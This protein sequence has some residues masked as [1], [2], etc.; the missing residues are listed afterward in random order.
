[1]KVMTK[2]HR[3]GKDPHTE[4]AGLGFLLVFMF[5]MALPIWERY[6]GA[7]PAEELDQLD[8]D[9]DWPSGTAAAIVQRLNR[10]KKFRAEL[11]AYV[12]EGY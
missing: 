5:K 9:G 10:D 12:A 7:V 6:H 1:M 8:K 3:N 2:S 4:D 11:Q